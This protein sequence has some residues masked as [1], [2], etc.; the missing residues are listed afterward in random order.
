MEVNKVI[1]DSGFGYDI[2]FIVG[3]GNPM[4]SVTVDIQTGKYPGTA[5][6]SENEVKPYTE[7][8]LEEMKAKY[9]YD[10]SIQVK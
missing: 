7:S 4:G 8:L 2:G 10:R 9:K 1:W 5:A 3:S 6:C